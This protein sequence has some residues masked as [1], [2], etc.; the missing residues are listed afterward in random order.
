M[1]CLG[2]MERQG[3]HEGTV[4]YR[5]MTPNKLYGLVP[6]LYIGRDGNTLFKYKRV[7]FQPIGKDGEEDPVNQDHVWTKY[8]G[9]NE[10]VR[11]G[12]VRERERAQAFW[13]KYNR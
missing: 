4:A 10:T 7:P 8:K 11:Q 1:I 13:D 6:A 9:S 3:Q 12:A 5:E 2:R